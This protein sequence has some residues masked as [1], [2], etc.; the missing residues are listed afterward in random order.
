M[1]PPRRDPAGKDGIVV[2]GSAYLLFFIRCRNIQ[3]LSLGETS[4]LMNQLNASE[5]IA[6]YHPFAYSISLRRTFSGAFIALRPPEAF[7]I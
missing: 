6:L 5:V 1:P 2:R 7:L 4:V 3:S